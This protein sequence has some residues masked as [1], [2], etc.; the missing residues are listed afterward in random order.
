MLQWV[1][2]SHSWDWLLRLLFTT[3]CFDCWR[4]FGLDCHFF[5]FLNALCLFS[6]ALCIS[7][8][9]LR[10]KLWMQ[11]KGTLLWPFD[12]MGT[13]KYWQA[14]QNCHVPTTQVH[15][16]TLD[17]T[18]FHTMF[19]LSMIYLNSEDVAK[20]STASLC[21]LSIPK[22]MQA[23]SYVLWWHFGLSIWSSNEVLNRIFK[24]HIHRKFK[25]N[26]LFFLGL[27]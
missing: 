14:T 24:L 11:W 13:L 18:Q 2:P 22:L 6:G 26:I 16:N 12:W 15:K 17:H 4:L 5:F 20:F 9:T 25:K 19:S 10:E 27:S 21:H 1:I 3:S 23:P 8:Q 7:F